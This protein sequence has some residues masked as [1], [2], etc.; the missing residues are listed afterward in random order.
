MCVCSYTISVGGTPW[1]NSTGGSFAGYAFSSSGHT[2]S[3]ANGNLKVVGSP[4]ISSGHDGI[5]KFDSVTINWSA[6]ELS[7]DIEWS[8]TTRAYAGRSGA[9]VFEQQWHTDTSNIAG[10]SAFPAFSATKSAPLLGFSEYTGSS[11][12]FMT[13]H[14]HGFPGIRGGK[15]NGYMVFSPMDTTPHGTGTNY[16]LAIGPLTEQFVNQA[17]P[18]GDALVYGMGESFSTAPPGYKISTL[19]VASA[20]GDNSSTFPQSAAERVSVRSGG[21]NAVLF[22]YGDAQL[23]F[24][25][26]SRARGDHNAE[27]KHLG[28]SVTG[29]YFYK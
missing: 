4:S 27:T 10:G 1:F 14:G 3:L 26:K 21:T 2:F 19:L 5:G 11:C 28:Y 15:G 8:T 24:Y 17:R 25:N 20:A 16:S 23:S 13:H 22:E 6:E 18:D 29:Y 7:S 12:G 9:L